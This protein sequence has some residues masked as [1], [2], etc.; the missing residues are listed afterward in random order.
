MQSGYSTY[1]VETPVEIKLQT[2]TWS[3][4]IGRILSV[5]KLH[6]E[7]NNFNKFKVT[8]NHI[9]IDYIVKYVEYQKLEIGI[10]APINQIRIWKR[11]YLLYEL[12]GLYGMKQMREFREIEAKS[13]II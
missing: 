8:R 3:N 13:S 6:I 5:R 12:V 1:A 9:I 2:R 7:N 10:L 4:E 11:V